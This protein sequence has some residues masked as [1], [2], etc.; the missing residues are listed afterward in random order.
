MRN[1]L[2]RYRT[3]TTALLLLLLTACSTAQTDA[4]HGPYRV[5]RVIDGDTIILI[6]NDTQERVRLLNV[7]TPETVHPD[8]TRNLD[9]PWGQLASDYA[10]SLLDGTHVTITLD[11]E[12]RDQYGRILAGVWL[13]HP[14]GTHLINGQPHVF[15]NEQIAL[16]GFAEVMVIP[17]NVKYVDVIRAAVAD[18]QANQRGMWAQ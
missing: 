17:P 10:K 2:N 14:Q 6:I 4:H 3:L 11:V 9:S 7:D 12:Q 8:D 1:L 15:V 13:A 16:N 18:A 5:H